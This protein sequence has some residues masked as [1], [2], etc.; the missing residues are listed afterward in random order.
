MKQHSTSY[1]VGIT[2]VATL[3]GLL[4]GYDT[5]VISGAEK[6]I[7][8]YLINGLGLGSLAHGATISSALIGCIIGG[9]VSG[10][11]ASKLGRKNSLMVAALLFFV[12]ALGSGWPE[13]LFFT[14]GV[15]TMGLLF[16]FNFYR[17]IG[18]IGVGIASAVCP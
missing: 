3:G 5:A 14:K 4:F 12:S 1:V 10:L 9:M 18:G 6:S 2:M 17:I 15:P 16:M 8:L 13:T 7:Q 11:A